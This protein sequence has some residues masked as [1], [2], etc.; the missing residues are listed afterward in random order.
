MPEPSRWAPE[1]EGFRVYDWRYR[2]G[3]SRRQLAQLLTM[4]EQ[5]AKTIDTFYLT[6]PHIEN[7]GLARIE[8]V[9]TMRASAQQQDGP[10]FSRNRLW[11]VGEQYMR[12]RFR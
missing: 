4:T 7:L 9:L 12:E 5:R 10:S 8:Y 2:W 1:L 3:F 6:N 11:A